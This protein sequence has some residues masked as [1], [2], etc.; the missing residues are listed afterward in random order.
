M[1]FFLKSENIQ[2]NNVLKAHIPE[3]IFNRCGCQKPSCQ[4]VRFLNTGHNFSQPY[5]LQIIEESCQK[6]GY[7][8]QQFD[9][10]HHNKCLDTTC[11]I[12]FSGLP[13]NAQLELAE[14][15]KT[16]S[17][18]PVTIGLQ[19][20]NGSRLLGE[21]LPGVSLWD[22]LVNLCPN[23]AQTHEP[24]VIIYMRRE[25]CGVHSLQST[26]LR[27]LGLTNGKAILRLLHR[28]K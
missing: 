18:S 6:L 23:E 1:G 15:L 27:V 20:E 25:I 26:T 10:K 13:N 24:P 7:D 4:P 8:P 14:A 21:F 5:N 11:T 19:L 12:R 28:Y 22:I 2:S 9:I 3:A 16:R 17:E